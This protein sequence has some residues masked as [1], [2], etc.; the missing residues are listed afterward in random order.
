MRSRSSTPRSPACRGTRSGRGSGCLAQPAAAPGRRRGRRARTHEG[1]GV[2]EAVDGEAG[3]QRAERVRRPRSRAPARR[4]SSARC[5]GVPWAPIT[6]FIPM[7]TN[8]KAMPSSVLEKIQRL[9]AREERTAARAE[10][11]SA[12]KRGGSGRRGPTRSI[13]RPALDRQQHRQQRRTAPSARRRRAPRRPARARTATSSC[14]RRRRPGGRASSARRSRRFPTPGLPDRQRDAQA[15]ERRC[16][17]RRA[18]PA[19]TPNS[20][21][22]STTA[23]TA[24]RYIMLV[25]RLASP[26]RVSQ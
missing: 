12:A 25:T 15:G 21:S 3:H 23:N 2:A 20:A 18:R 14:A 9:A 13:S 8:M 7:C 22:S 24:G 17:P 5:S 19:R 26:W 4:S 16:R 11:T 1:V 10:A 6:L